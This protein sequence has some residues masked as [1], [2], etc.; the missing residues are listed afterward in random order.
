MHSTT[1]LRIK[2]NAYFEFVHV[3]S[4]FIYYISMQC[5]ILH[6]DLE[7]AND[8]RALQTSFGLK[9]TCFFK[10]FFPTKPRTLQF[11]QDGPK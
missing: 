5:S 3:F 7:L 11:I 1:V 4:D 2:N 8:L 9:I 10:R 6:A